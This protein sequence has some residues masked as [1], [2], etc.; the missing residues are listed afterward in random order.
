MTQIE[1][2]PCITQLLDDVVR[3]LYGGELTCVG[4]GEE[5]GVRGGRV[6]R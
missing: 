3:G 1:C 4:V 6:F 2:I 5:T